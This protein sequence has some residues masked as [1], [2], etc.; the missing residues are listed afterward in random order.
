MPRSAN[1]EA[2]SF[3]LAYSHHVKI[4]DKEAGLTEPSGLALSLDRTVLWTISDDTRRVFQLSLEGDLLEDKSIEV[5]DKGLEGI[6]LDPAGGTLLAV[7]EETNE[8]LTI[9]IKTHEVKGYALAD[10]KCYDEVARYF[11]GKKKRKKKDNNK[12]LEGITCN[13]ETGTIFVLKEQGPGLLVEVSPNLQEILSHKLLNDQNGFCDPDLAPDEI[14]FSDLCYDPS[15]GCV[16]I[17][18]DQASR[19]FLYDWKDNRVIH[20]EKLS[21]SRK[22]KDRPIKKAEGV[23]IDPKSNRLYVVSDAKAQLYVYQIDP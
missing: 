14:D 19:L 5:A 21:Y 10:M 20:S 12:G 8:I 1:L 6:A 17:I 9:D 3:T 23:A 7:K 4:K 22:G 2:H 15:R 18:S 13:E 11:A 16:W